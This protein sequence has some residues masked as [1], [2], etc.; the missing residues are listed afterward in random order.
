MLSVQKN[1]EQ[2]MQD[3]TRLAAIDLGSNSFRLEMGHLDEGHYARTDY[4]KETI[5][6]GNGLDADHNLN[7]Q[8]MQSGW[9]CL[10]RF[11]ARLAGFNPTQVKAVATQTLREANN[12]DDFLGKASRILGFP[13][14]VIS[15][16]E[17]ARL[18]YQGVAHGLPQDQERRLVVDIGGRSTELMLGQGLA[19][20]LLASYPVGSIAWS[21]RY[22]A[23]NQFS[24]AAFDVAEIAAKDVLGDALQNCQ[25]QSWDVAY[26]SAGTV[27]AVGDVLLAAGWPAGCINRDGLDWLQNQLIQAKSGDRICLEGM[28]E[29]RRPILG[30][31]LSVMR[32]VF[33]LLHI[34]KMHKAS[35][36]LRHGVMV[37]L[38]RVQ[39]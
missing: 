3:G 32:A 15:G 28:K 6:Q 33:D 8:A 5:R 27:G 29:D 13:I 18:I 35:G 14:E 20:T 16:Q 7:P 10:A 36:G 39:G 37:D 30:G 34:D 1:G 17:E 31:G 25:R 24:Q 12:R 4:L 26:G 9:D 21:N 22:F 19:P 23:N 11:G 38:M 2:A